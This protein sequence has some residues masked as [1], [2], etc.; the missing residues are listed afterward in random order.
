MRDPQV[1]FNLFG[2]SVLK[3]G[4]ERHHGPKGEFIDA[5][6]KLESVGCFGLTEVAFVAL[7][8]LSLAGG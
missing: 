6:D 8:F 4:T 1:Q 7:S 5:I 3:L 2:G